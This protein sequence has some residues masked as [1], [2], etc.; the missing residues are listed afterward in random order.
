MYISLSELSP[1]LLSEFKSE[2][3]FLYA[4]QQVQEGFTS[5]RE[6]IGDYLQVPKL[7]SAYTLF[8]LPTNIKRLEF[9]KRVLSP[10]LKSIAV[11]QVVDIGCGPGTFTLGLLEIFPDASFELVDKST[12]M[13]KQ[14]QKIISHYPLKNEFI[15]SESVNRHSEQSLFFFGH[16]VNEIGL[17][18]FK[19]MIDDHGP[20]ELM[21]LEPGTKSSFEAIIKLREFLIESG[22]NLIFPCPDHS[23]CPMSETEN[24]C[25]FNYY[26]T[27]DSDMERICQL[28]KIDRH[29]SPVIF[30]YFS[31][32]IKP[33]SDRRPLIRLKQ[34]T[35]FSLVYE[36]CSGTSKI[37]NL[38]LMK[39]KYKKKE[40]KSFKHKIGL[41]PV[42]ETEQKNDDLVFIEKVT[43]FLEDEKDES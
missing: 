38:V 30:F 12:L 21:I 40:Q 42:G 4:L 37:D 23:L 3:D 14:A 13:L 17:N 33:L 39:K 41:T 8:Y 1:L 24:W 16:S 22:Y 20:N 5:N 25:H 29:T 10:Y 19:K 15:F 32:T 2:G 6:R 31:K 36:A 7:V 27:Y 43:D 9:V 26:T 28:A 11:N 35:K 34:E 18:G